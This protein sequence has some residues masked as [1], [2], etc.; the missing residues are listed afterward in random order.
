MYSPI[1]FLRVNTT[2]AFRVHI[3]FSSIGALHFIIRFR[4]LLRTHCSETRGVKGMRTIIFSLKR[5]PRVRRHFSI[6]DTVISRTFCE[7]TSLVLASNCNSFASDCLR[8][9]FWTRRSDRRAILSIIS[10]VYSCSSDVIARKVI[11][12]HRFIF[13]ITLSMRRATASPSTATIDAPN[14]R[15]TLIQSVSA[16]CSPVTTT[17]RVEIA[18]SVSRKRRIKLRS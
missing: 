16:V 7:R 2:L 13:A 6:R 18:G 10:L 12:L 3:R 11:C 14:I 1:V 15:R 8:R 5:I 9:T 4:A 17:R